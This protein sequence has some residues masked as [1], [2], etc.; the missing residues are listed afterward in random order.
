M[1]NAVLNGAA[2]IM[3]RQV[4]LRL[5]RRGVAATIV[6]DHTAVVKDTIADGPLP[7]VFATIETISR[8][9]GVQH[10]WLWVHGELL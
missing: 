9:T 5:N 2:E 1:D 6:R 3:L 4:V 8:K 10:P 7:T